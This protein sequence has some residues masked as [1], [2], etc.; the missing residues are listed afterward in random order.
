M[1]I[2]IL[3]KEDREMMNRH[4]QKSPTRCKSN[5]K[6]TTRNN[7]NDE[8]KYVLSYGDAHN[9]RGAGDGQL[10]ND[11]G[12]LLR[13]MNWRDTT[14]TTTTNTTTTNT[15][16]A[17]TTTTKSQ[18]PTRTL[19]RRRMIHMTRL[20]Q[21]SDSI[22]ENIVKHVRKES[23][24]INHLAD[25]ST[26]YPRVHQVALPLD[27]MRRART[28]LA[29]TANVEYLQKNRHEWS[30]IKI[31]PMVIKATASVGSS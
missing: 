20:F 17:E 24:D 2:G 28:P 1:Q 11:S 26:R 5:T 6:R 8:W 13:I 10:C 7:H 25:G 14:T 9:Q 22:R 4:R 21:A 3:F 27:D 12:N 30:D 15:T 23:G 18:V 16:I 29:W 19:E 31:A